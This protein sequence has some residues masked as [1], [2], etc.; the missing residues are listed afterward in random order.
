MSEMQIGK[1]THFY[2]K[3]GV[4]VLALNDMIRVGDKVHF[5]GHATDFQQPVT[6]LQVDH[7]AVSEG[8]PAQEVA[9]KVEQRVHPHDV[10]LKV[11]D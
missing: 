5:H 8:R 4:A 10:V 7:H 3:I 9:L 2:D 6:S 11:S 1:V